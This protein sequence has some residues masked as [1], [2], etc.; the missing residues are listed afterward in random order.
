MESLKNLVQEAKNDIKKA[1]S[2]GLLTDLEIKWLGRKGRLTEILR[3][4]KNLPER[5]R[6]IQGAEANR[7]RSELE[8]MIRV[9]RVALRDEAARNELERERIDVTLP[10]KG[11]RAG[12]IH[13]L[14]RTLLEIRGIFE[15]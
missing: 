7:A 9:R 5:E 3:N 11:L 8:E 15:R 12:R 14:T 6:R 10:G 2:E 4:L 13:P 1:P